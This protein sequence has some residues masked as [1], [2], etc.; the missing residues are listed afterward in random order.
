VSRKRSKQVT[1]QRDSSEAWEKLRK[2]EKSLSINRA[3][4]KV[5]GYPMTCDGVCFSLQYRGWLS[6]PSLEEKNGR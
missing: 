2:M 4:E 5:T 1:A 6:S 3:I